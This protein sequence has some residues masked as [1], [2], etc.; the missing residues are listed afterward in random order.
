MFGR[1]F[2]LP[3][4]FKIETQVEVGITEVIPLIVRDETVSIGLRRLENRLNRSP[5]G[6]EVVDLLHRDAGV[7]LNED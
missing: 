4:G 2:S 3:E 5:A 1:F 6:K 7:T